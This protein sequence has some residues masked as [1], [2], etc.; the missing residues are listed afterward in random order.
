[1]MNET[2]TRSP[3][4]RVGS[5]HPDDGG[6]GPPVSGNRITENGRHGIYYLHHWYAAAHNRAVRHGRLHPRYPDP[7]PDANRLHNSNHDAD[8]SRPPNPNDWCLLDENAP[9]Y[10]LSPTGES[11]SDRDSHPAMSGTG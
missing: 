7:H 5:I 6:N 9:G 11:S 1:M 4:V 2:G 8:S 3:V 10:S